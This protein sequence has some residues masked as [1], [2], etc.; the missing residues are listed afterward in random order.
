MCAE[1]YF[2]Q[3]RRNE[4]TNSGKMDYSSCEK[5]N[6]K[7]NNSTTHQAGFKI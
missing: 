4:K 1:L 6:I 2:T 5:W 3:Q 7:G